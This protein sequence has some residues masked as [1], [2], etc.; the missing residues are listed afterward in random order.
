MAALE[1]LSAVRVRNAYANLAF[2]A[3]LRRH[4]LREG[5]AGQLGDGRAISLGQVRAPGPGGALWELQ[6]KGAGRTPYSRTADGRAVLRSSLREFACSEA[7]HWLGVPSTR[8]LS[9]VAAD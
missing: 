3:I 8:A 2:P 9:L 4:G 1:L 7:M 5:W 6:L